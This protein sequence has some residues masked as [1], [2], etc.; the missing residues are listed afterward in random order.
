V[1]L[2][3]CRKPGRFK[4]RQTQGAP[5]CEASARGAEPAAVEAAVASTAPMREERRQPQ[6]RSLQ[7]LLPHQVWATAILCLRLTPPGNAR[8]EEVHRSPPV[9]G[10]GTAPI[11]GPIDASVQ[12]RRLRSPPPVTRNPTEKFA[13]LPNVDHTTSSILNGHLK[14]RVR[15]SSNEFHTFREP[16]PARA[17][18][19]QI[20]VLHTMVR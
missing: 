13:V 12:L 19:Q 3:G 18:D 15:I 5:R 4:E 8:A 2:R 1:N 14:R 16:R 10:S 6:G 7:C 11:C 17:E 20:L 9:D